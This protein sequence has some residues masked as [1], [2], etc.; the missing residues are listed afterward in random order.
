[1]PETRAVPPVSALEALPGP[2][3]D[4]LSAR[5]V[6]PSGDTTML[7]YRRIT[8]R[9][10]VEANRVSHPYPSCAAIVAQLGLAGARAPPR[11]E[12]HFSSNR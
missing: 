12:G 11:A 10:E 7:K 3:A 5:G 8:Y 1:M 2:Q 6:V 9:P 4:T